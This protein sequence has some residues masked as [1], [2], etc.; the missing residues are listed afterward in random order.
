MHL[1]ISIGF[2]LIQF[3]GFLTEASRLPIRV[4]SGFIKRWTLICAVFFISTTCQCFSKTTI[5][6]VPVAS[7]TT[8][9]PR[10]T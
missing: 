10:I 7:P 3:H 5:E 4:F 6:D 9:A 2:Q 1:Y 8:D